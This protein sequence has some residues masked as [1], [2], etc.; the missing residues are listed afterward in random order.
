MKKIQLKKGV[1]LYF[2]RNEKFKTYMASVLFHSPLTL[3]GASKSSLL[4]Q[5]LKRG[6]EKYLSQRELNIALDELYG[7]SLYCSSGKRG[8]DQI[9]RIAVEGV[10][11]EFL[12]TP[13]FD[14]L[15]ELLFSAAF[16]GG[17]G[18]AFNEEY[19]AQEKSN[20][21]DRIRN[22][23]SDKRWYSLLRLNEVMFE[24]D[25]YGINTAGS[26]EEVKKITSEELYCYYREIIERAPVDIIITGN[27]NE[28]D[29][30]NDVDRAAAFLGERDAVYTPTRPM[31]ETAGV[32]RVT[33][34]M[35]VTQGKLAMGF[36]TGITY[37]HPLV[38]AQTVFNTI[39]GSGANSKLFN[40]VREKLS[41][42]Y[43]ASSGIDPMKGCMRISSGI[44]FKN[45]EPAYNEIL[46]QLDNMVKGEFNSDEIDTAKKEIIN[47]YRSRLDST[48]SMEDYYT[49]QI[50][51]GTDVSIDETIEKI[52]AVTK[53]EIVETAKRIKLNTVYFLTGKEEA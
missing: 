28:D 16:K 3:D 48:E 36:E 46:A 25:P 4:S 45:F 53:E 7:A 1:N 10:C 33:D 50:L 38:Y 19:V 40:N 31:A 32:K 35:D 39:Y 24:G 17:C 8:G 47:M 18:G 51:L 27:F 15:M 20:L 23:I 12:P 34:R 29:A 11:D 52:E 44:E 5:V 22:Q 13:A 49:N 21:I 14:K 41:L 30:Y 2:I 37:G 26:E 6:N 9:L 43:Y 42:C